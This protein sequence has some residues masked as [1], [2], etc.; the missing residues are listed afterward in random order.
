MLIN[1]RIL[2]YWDGNHIDLTLEKKTE[3]EKIIGVKEIMI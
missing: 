2:K 1:K 3:S